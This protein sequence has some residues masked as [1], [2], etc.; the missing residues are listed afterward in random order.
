LLE[1]ETWSAVLRPGQKPRWVSPNFAASYFKALNKHFSSKAKERDCLGNTCIL[2][3]LPSCVLGWSPR[4]SNLSV[5]SNYTR[6][7]DTHE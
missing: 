1:N 6:L 2:S 3:C 5:P 4:F 7:L